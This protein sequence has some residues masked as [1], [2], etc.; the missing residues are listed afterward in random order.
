MNQVGKERDRVRNEENADLRRCR[1]REDG[2][3]DPNRLEPRVGANDRAI[4]E[5]MRMAVNVAVVML[6]PRGRQE[7]SSIG[8]ARPRRTCSM[9]YSA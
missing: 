6:V 1:D 3:A 4:N 8:S 7:A 5:A 2:E 9:W